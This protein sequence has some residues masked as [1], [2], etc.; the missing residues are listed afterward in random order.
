MNIKNSYN[1]YKLNLKDKEF[2]VLIPDVEGMK[3][4]V[5]PGWRYH[6]DVSCID[7][8]ITYFR[9]LYGT[10]ITLIMYPECIIYLPVKDLPPLYDSYRMYERGKMDIVFYNHQIQ[11]KR[12]LWVKIRSMIQ[13]MTPQKKT[14]KYDPVFLSDRCR[15]LS[16]SYRKSKIYWSKKSD[17]NVNYNHYETLFIEGSRYLYAEDIERLGQFISEELDE[18]DFTYELDSIYSYSPHIY[19]LGIESGYYPS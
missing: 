8:N 15:K 3:A 14:L 7:G 17:W 6:D 18:D 1:E 9:A 5:N 13:H 19:A 10:A 2:R 4:W 12:S 16:E 11:L